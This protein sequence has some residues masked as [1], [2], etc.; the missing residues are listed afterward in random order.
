M[1]L[2]PAWVLASS[3]IP[4]LERAVDLC[5][6]WNFLVGSPTSAALLGYAYTLSERIAE[7]LPLLIEAVAQSSSTRILFSNSLEAAC[8]G[9]ACLLA[10]KVDNAV[11]VAEHAFEVARERNE[12]GYQAWILR[13]QGEIAASTKHGTDGKAKSYYEQ[14]AALAIELAMR[15]LEAQCRFA[16]EELARKAGEPREAQE[17]FEKAVSMFRDMGMQSWLEKAEAP[18]KAL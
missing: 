10:D 16:L 2:K 7:G 3:T 9:E 1:S 15:P 13:L 5:K 18:L 17:Q 12:R 11:K 4:A 6:T 14:A 8:L